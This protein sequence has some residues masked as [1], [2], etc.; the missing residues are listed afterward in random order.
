MCKL[1]K[2]TTSKNPIRDILTPVSCPKKEK[3]VTGTRTIRTRSWANGDRPC[4]FPLNSGADHPIC[5]EIP[6]TL[7]WSE[8]ISKNEPQRKQTGVRSDGPK[9]AEGGLCVFLFV[10]FFVHKRDHGDKVFWGYCILLRSVVAV[11]QVF[12]QVATEKSPNGLSGLCTVTQ[13]S[14]KKRN[15]VRTRN[16]RARVLGVFLKERPALSAACGASGSDG[17]LG[18][19]GPLDLLLIVIVEP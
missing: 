15:F 16:G 2:L 10:Q 5:L 18:D 9:R 12:H 7:C 4:F 13:Q 1:G 11:R 17:T 6:F 3:V 14:K 19:K 8:A